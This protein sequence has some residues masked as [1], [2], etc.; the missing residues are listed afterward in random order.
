M[1]VLFHIWPEQTYRFSTRRLLP[2]KKNR[3]SSES[4]PSIPYEVLESKSS[5]I[6]MMEEVNLITHGLSFDLNNLKNLK[7]HTF[8]MSRHG[9]NLT[10]RVDNKGSIIHVNPKGDATRLPRY[11]MPVFIHPRDEVILS[12]QYTARSFLDERLMEIGLKS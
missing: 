9:S 1:M 4:K 3:Y 2:A 10:L 7:G 11:T 6:P 12:D 5:R 8:I